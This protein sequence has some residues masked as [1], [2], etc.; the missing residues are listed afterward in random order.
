MLESLSKNIKNI[1][2]FNSQAAHV[3][4]ARFKT[5]PTTQSSIKSM[6]LNKNL[7]F[8]VAAAGIDKLSYSRVVVH[9]S[10]SVT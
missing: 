10:L 2:D 8:F 4:P 6:P 7:L 9:I 5:K 1:L 3:C